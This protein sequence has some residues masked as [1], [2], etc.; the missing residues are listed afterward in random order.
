MNDNDPKESIETY[1]EKRFNSRRSYPGF[2]K[3]K[4]IKNTA[5]IL[6]NAVLIAFMIYL[7]RNQDEAPRYFSKTVN[8]VDASYRL[9]ISTSS[10]GDI[11]AGLTIRNTGF[12]KTIFI[13]KHN[14]ADLTI[15]HKEN[16][17]ARQSLAPEH[18]DISI[19]PGKSK[20]IA[21]S[22]EK[23]SIML[24]TKTADGAV[25]PQG[26]FSFFLKSKSSIPLSAQMRI[27]RAEPVTITIDF[28]YEVA[29]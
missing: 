17:L 23:S 4:K 15:Y 5:L 21:A 13:L 1:I 22:I 11:T 8:T 14:S 28:N 19:E 16:E 7:Y 3:K 29:K 24:Y 6:I 27:L 26:R 2:H 25:E 20:S 18:G 9:S 12:R 10:D